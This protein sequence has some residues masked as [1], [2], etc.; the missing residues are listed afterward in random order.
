MGTPTSKSFL[1]LPNS[2]VISNLESLG[3]S[4]GRSSEESL[5]F[6]SVLKS[7]EADRF[8]VSSKNSVHDDLTISDVDEEEGDARYD[9]HLLTHL[10]RRRVR[11]GTG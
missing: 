2:Q 10:F 4:L 9:G 5:V 7:V 11:G 6:V 8:T 3:L 1:P